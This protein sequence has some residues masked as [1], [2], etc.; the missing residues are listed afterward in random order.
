M[1]YRLRTLLI[2]VT[3]VCMVCGWYAHV[4]R[5]AAYHWTK[6][7]GGGSAILPNYPHPAMPLF[8]P[9]PEEYQRHLDRAYDFDHALFRPWLAFVHCKPGST[10]GAP[11]K[12]PPSI[13]KRLQFRD[14]GLPRLDY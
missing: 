10:F 12:K 14:N 7:Y 3:A 13:V 11:V 4:R 6:G 1:R 8:V 5:M 9:L 2:F